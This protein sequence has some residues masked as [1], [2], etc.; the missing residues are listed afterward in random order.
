MQ[1]TA[2]SP[3]SCVLEPLAGEGREEVHTVI[4]NNYTWHT[5][6]KLNERVA[7]FVSGHAVIII[8]RAVAAG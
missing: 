6:H 7:G 8:Q 2:A 5:C 1:W 4:G 3:R